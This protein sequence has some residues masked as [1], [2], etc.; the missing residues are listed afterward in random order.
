MKQYPIPKKSLLQRRMF[1][2]EIKKQVVKDV[3]AG[4]CS[5]NEAC[6]ELGINNSTVYKWLNK[7]SRYLQRNK[8]L[9]VENKSEAYRTKELEKRL[10]DLEATI[11]RKQMEIDFLSKIIELAGNELKMDLKKSF[12][13]KASDGSSTTKGSG[14]TTK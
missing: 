9:V 4:K 6:N 13:T 12:F 2:E 11:G 1:S 8:I 7:Y 3:E 14:T 10:L 5:I